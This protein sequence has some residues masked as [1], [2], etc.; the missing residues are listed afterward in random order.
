MLAACGSATH[1]SESGDPFGS[2]PPPPVVINPPTT[3]PLLPPAPPST[4]PPSTPP[5]SVPT[6]VTVAGVVTFDR[7]PFGATGTGLDFPATTHAPVRGATVEAIAATGGAVLATTRTNATGEYSLVVPVSTQ[8]FVRVKAELVKS[9][10]PS[11]TVRVRDNT[12]GNALYALDSAAFNSGSGASVTRDLNAGSGFSTASGSY[13]G[14]RSAA[15]FSLLD[16]AYQSIQLVL[17]ADPNAVFPEL[18]FS[19]SPQNTPVAGNVALGQIETTYYDSPLGSRPATIYVLGDADVDT[20]EFDRHVIAREWGQ[21]YQEAFGR[22]DTVGGEYQLNERLNFRLAFSGGFADAFSGIVNADPIYRDSYGP[23]LAEDDEDD[24]EATASVFRH[25]WYSEPSI[26]QLIY[27]LYDDGNDGE[28]FQLGFGPLHTAMA[29]LR[30][31]H[32][33]TGIH[34]FMSRVMA[35]VPAQAAAI[36][37]FTAN[38]EQIV[39]NLN[40]DYAASETNSAGGRV[41]LP[42]YA[43]IVPGQTKRVCSGGGPTPDKIYNKLGNTSLLRLTLAAPYTGTLRARRVNPGLDPDILV[44]RDG[45]LIEAGE[46]GPGSELLSLTGLPAGDY[47]LETYEKANYWDDSGPPIGNVCIDVSL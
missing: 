4:P 45:V 31:T 38:R 10:A 35:A 1:H 20:D 40:D 14:A 41:E 19:W 15:P 47:V 5:P 43:S 37:T 21:Y 22:D 24:L 46:G 39:V 16:V 12:S 34:A 42:L 3:P 9:G 23:G 17:T 29:G 8:V 11:W 13:T 7:V 18:R 33:M 44:W 25:G 6:D 36:K 32:A 26:A 2:A 30:T 27:D 28:S